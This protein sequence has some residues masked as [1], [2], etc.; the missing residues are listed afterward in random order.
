MAVRATASRRDG[1]AHDLEVD[2][3]SLVTDEPEAD[4]GT[5]L[6]ASPT[7]LMA[8]ALAGCTAITIEMYAER[9][10]WEL[11]HVEVDVEMTSEPERAFTVTLKVACDL[12]EEQLERLRVIAGKCPVHKALAGEMPVSIEDRIERV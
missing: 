8:A 9:K 1:Y 12:D 6:G 3:H 10:G 2:G 5:D 4:G 7:R 11:G